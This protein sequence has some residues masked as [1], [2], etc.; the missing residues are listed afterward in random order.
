MNWKVFLF[1]NA[2]GGGVWTT[3]MVFAGYLLGEQT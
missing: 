2:V 3:T 1:Y